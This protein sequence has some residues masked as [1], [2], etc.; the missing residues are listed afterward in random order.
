MVGFHISK[1]MLPYISVA[2][3]WDRFTKALENDTALQV[4][5]N[6]DLGLVYTPSGRKITRMAVNQA[7]RDYMLYDGIVD[8][9]DTPDWQTGIVPPESENSRGRF[10]T[11]HMGIDVSESRHPTVIRGIR[12][13]NG[14]D[15]LLY[16]GRPSWDYLPILAR[17]YQVDVAVIDIDPETTKAKEFQGACSA[18]VW[19]CHYPD[20]GRL[21]EPSWDYK[22]RIVSADRTQSLDRTFARI[23]RQEATFPKDVFGIEGGEYVKELT[24]STRI[25]DEKKERFVWTKTEDHFFHAENYCRLGLELMEDSGGYS[26]SI[27]EDM[28]RYYP[29]DEK[30]IY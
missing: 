6:S 7:K 13:D 5:Y 24:T 19:L 15:Q 3:L 11:I 8:Y 20:S 2:E 18:I 29:E 12:K 10:D 26:S 22:E 14:Q 25:F 16:V 30:E 1:L 28:S 4:F 21:K 27:E 9:D 17:M 23:V